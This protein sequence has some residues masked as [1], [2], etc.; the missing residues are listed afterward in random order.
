L[1]AYFHPVD[2]LIVLSRY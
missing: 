2:T 1:S